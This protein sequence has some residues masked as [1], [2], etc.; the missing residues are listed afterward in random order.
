M[1]CV[2][3]DEEPI[4]IREYIPSYY[5]RSPFTS[6]P[7][8]ME[9]P[10]SQE[11]T[12]TDVSFPDSLFTKFSEDSEAET[13]VI[14]MSPTNADALPRISCSK[15][16]STDALP[17]IL[18]GPVLDQVRELKHPLALLLYSGDT[19]AQPTP[20]LPQ[21]RFLD[22]LRPAR[23]PPLGRAPSVKTRVPTGTREL[24][25]QMAAAEQPS[26]AWRMFNKN[27]LGPI[28]VSDRATRVFLVDQSG[29]VF[30]SCHS[31]TSRQKGIP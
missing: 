19:S 31:C 16:E 30:R 22:P 5:I 4:V 10:P 9:R 1:T 20:K 8:A 18:F 6:F 17:D 21:M 2:A 26:Q 13:H 23:R 29:H 14:E 28:L 12:L 27:S 25:S 15:A 11:S 24:P 7:L 3:E